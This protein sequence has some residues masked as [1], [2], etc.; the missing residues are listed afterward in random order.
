MKLKKSKIIHYDYVF[1][2]Y[3]NT[4]EVQVVH[5]YYRSNMYQ[6]YTDNGIIQGIFLTS[7]YSYNHTDITY[8][9]CC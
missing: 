3:N 7:P 5:G 8:E 4:R 2:K 1:R 9:F 6:C